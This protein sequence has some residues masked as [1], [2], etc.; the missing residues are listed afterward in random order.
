MKVLK[1]F[2][3]YGVLLAGVALALSGYR[4]D[5][6]FAM[7]MAVALKYNP[8]MPILNQVIIAAVLIALTIAYFT[9][10]K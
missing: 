9:S 10:K 7:A 3:F 1:E 8:K 6:A 2:A 5:A 4:Q